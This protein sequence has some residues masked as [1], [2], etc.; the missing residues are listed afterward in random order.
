[1]FPWIIHV[2]FSLS[3]QLQ[4]GSAAPAYAK[5]FLQHKFWHSRLQIIYRIVIN[6]N[7]MKW[8]Y[9]NNSCKHNNIEKEE[10]RKPAAGETFFY[11][12]CHSRT[13]IIKGIV[14]AII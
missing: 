3:P 5:L 12:I 1:M 7:L 13:Q 2:L 4:F 10:R 8:K 6:G 14:N 11:S 9:K